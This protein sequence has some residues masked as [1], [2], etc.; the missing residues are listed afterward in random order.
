MQRQRCATSRSAEGDVRERDQDGR[1]SCGNLA[2]GGCQ[3]GACL[4]SAGRQ[5]DR[6]VGGFEGGVPPVAVRMLRGQG[7]RVG[8]P[9]GSE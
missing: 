4:C 2:F 7:C 9:G 5:D 1:D 6:S 3:S 8:L